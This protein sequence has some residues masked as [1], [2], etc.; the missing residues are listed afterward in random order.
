MYYLTNT[1]IQFIETRLQYNWHNYKN[2]DGL[3][4]R[5]A[6][7]LVILNQAQ[8]VAW[9]VGQEK[10]LKQL[11]D[12]TTKPLYTTKLY[13]RILFISHIRKNIFLYNLKNAKIRMLRG[14]F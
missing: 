6:S 7:N 11:G 8:R 10:I 5:L 3:V 13:E 4:N 1:I 14:G 9:L 12:A 2:G